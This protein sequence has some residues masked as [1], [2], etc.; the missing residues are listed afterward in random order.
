[1]QYNNNERPQAHKHNRVRRKKEPT[2]AAQKLLIIFCLSALLIL[3]V[4]IV[5]VISVGKASEAG[6]ASNQNVLTAIPVTSA[7]STSS[8]TSSSNVT[9]TSSAVSSSA[10]SSASSAVITVT[11]AAVSRYR[12]TVPFYLELPSDFS[13]EYSIEILYNGTGKITSIPNIIIP[14]MTSVSIELSFLTPEE[15][16]DAQAYLINASN[17]K[18]SLIGTLILNF[19]DSSADYS[20]FDTAAAFYAV[21]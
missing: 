16:V 7:V 5:C 15:S 10:V 20:G 17:S 1:M 19:A 4:F 21:Q 9:T 3:V 11:T 18:R 13:G 6:K 2:S 8:V 12:Y 14:D